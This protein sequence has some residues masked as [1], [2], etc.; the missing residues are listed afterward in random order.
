MV[1]FEIP[2][3]LSRKSYE[4]LKKRVEVMIQLAEGAIEEPRPDEAAN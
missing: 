1:A 4:V 2:S 3:A